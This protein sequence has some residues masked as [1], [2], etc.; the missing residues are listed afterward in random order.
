MEDNTIEENKKEKKPRRN[1]SHKNK[2]SPKNLNQKKSIVEYEA[3]K[4]DIQEFCDDN[5]YITKKLNS[6]KDK[7]I[8]NAYKDDFQ[9]HYYSKE[10]TFEDLIKVN[11]DLFQ[12]E[13]SLEDLNFYLSKSIKY[14]ETILKESND[15]LILTIKLI[16]NAG[17]VPQDFVL[18]KV[19]ISKEQLLIKKLNFLLEEKNKYLE[20]LKLNKMIEEKKEEDLISRYKYAEKLINS[21]HDNFK[22]VL[23]INL[24]TCCDILN[25]AED[26]KIIGDELKKIDDKYNNIF[27]KLVYR[28]TRDGD[29]SKDF[30]EK[31]DNI[32]PNITLVKTKDNHRFGGF[33][34]C[35]WK[36]LSQNIKNNNDEIGTGKKDKDA[37]CFSLD[38]NKIY[39]N[40]QMDKEA[41]FCC[42]KYGPTFCRN[43]FCLND[44]MLSKGG[45][46]MKKNT[47]YF[48]GQDEDYEISGG[49][50]VFEVQDVEVL[51]IIFA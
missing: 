43:I 51:E 30:H 40:C 36:H 25:S 28:A 37:F 38:L 46:C 14:N 26:W 13:K 17:G 22:K 34:Q 23:D 12:G 3:E 50:R 4:V 35:N 20:G 18:D 1:K 15:T 29:S 10:Y 48:M 41:I 45:Y 42:K 19:V 8:F 9:Y 49:N 24:I 7:L 33:T 2:D 27:F 39:P 31:C 44:E 16:T 32:G 11:E 6:T 47:S 5:Y 21:V